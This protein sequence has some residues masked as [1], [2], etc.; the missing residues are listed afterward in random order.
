MQLQADLLGVPV[1][2]AADP[3]T[4]ALGAAALA[5]EA[6]ASVPAGVVYEPL[7]ETARVR[8]LREAWSE[9]LG[10]ARSTQPLNG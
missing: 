6:G 3:E 5:S 1:A 10:R 2:V 4:T 7:L 9:A 8:E